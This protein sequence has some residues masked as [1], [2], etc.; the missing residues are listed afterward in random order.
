M[1]FFASNDR[2]YI[3]QTDGHVMFD[4]NRQS[5]HFVSQIT[6]PIVVDFPPAVNLGS[7]SVAV[8]APIVQLYKYNDWT[9]SYYI[10][11]L[12][13]GITNPFVYATFSSS[14]SKV[15]IYTTGT[16]VTGYSAKGRPIGD[17]NYSMFQSAIVEFRSNTDGNPNPWSYI[18]TAGSNLFNHMARTFELVIIGSS[19]YLRARQA[20]KTL[21]DGPGGSSSKVAGYTWTNFFTTFTGATYNLVFTVNVGGY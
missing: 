7:Y 1:S 9:G 21:V 6:V 15:D 17:G 5:P 19:I 4:T 16:T 3:T 13:S 12:P 8:R 14:M 18:G 10:G 11:E 20:S 2:I